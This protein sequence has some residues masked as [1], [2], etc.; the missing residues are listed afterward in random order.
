METKLV[1]PI[2]AI[3]EALNLNKHTSEEKLV[4]LVDHLR[5]VSNSNISYKEESVN[6]KEQLIKSDETKDALKKLIDALRAQV[7][8]TKEESSLKLKEET[9]KRLECSLK[10]E[11]QIKE[12]AVLVASHTDHNS[13]LREENKAITEN[14]REL[15][16]AYEEEQRKHTERRLQIQL[17]EAQMSKT[18]IER[19]ELTAEHTQDRLGLQQ[20]LLELR[21]ENE[22]YRQKERL[23]KEQIE[24]YRVQS[25]EVEKNLGDSGSSI[26]HFRKQ[27]EVL[28]VKL[29]Q[30]ECDTAEWKHKFEASNEQVKKMNKLSL[31]RDRELEVFKKK[32]TTMENLNRALNTELKKAKATN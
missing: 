12:L 29:R 1:E 23:M 10:F 2:S 17:L 3:M 6:L 8:L 14:M 21:E 9:Q 4:V 18:K 28:N 31:E 16:K 30:V 27:I 11:E 24:I 25:L 22:L 26:S 5:K 19:A 13:K 20:T 7:E 15:I 32:L